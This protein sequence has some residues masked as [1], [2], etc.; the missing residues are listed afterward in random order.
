MA[1]HLSFTGVCVIATSYA[2][3]E[4]HFSKWLVLDKR[5]ARA[6]LNNGH[7]LLWLQMNIDSFQ[8][9]FMF[10]C[11][12]FFALPSMLFFFFYYYYRLSDSEYGA[13]N[14]V[15]TEPPLNGKIIVLIWL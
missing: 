2:E 15:R 9:F 7:W 10:E 4:S 1:S 6:S 3:T 13:A 12:G 8:L 5:A 11:V 14:A